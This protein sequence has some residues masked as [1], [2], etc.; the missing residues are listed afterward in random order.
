MCHTG[1]GIPSPPYR[2][3]WRPPAPSPCNTGLSDDLLRYRAAVGEAYR[4]AAEINW[5]VCRPA[6]SFWPDTDQVADLLMRAPWH[7]SP[8]GTPVSATPTAR[9]L[10]PLVHGLPRNWPHIRAVYERAGFQHTGDTEVILLARVADLPEPEPR[11]GVTVERTL[12]ECGTRFTARAG[13]RILGFVEIDTALAR[14]ERHARAAGP[15]DIGN[16]HI[17]P[18]QDGTGLE[19]WLLA[20]AADWLR[21]CGVDRL[22]ASNPPPTVPCSG[23]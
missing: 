20:Q 13:T 23:T 16:L 7:S 22:V 2:T 6:A 1:P 15:A 17:D 21:L 10:P 5:F 9:C 14:P 4:D 3:A 11:P 12:G 19:H 18:A 8:A